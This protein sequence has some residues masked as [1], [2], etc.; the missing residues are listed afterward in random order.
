MFHVLCS[1]GVGRTENICF[2]H[3]FC[4]SNSN[5]FVSSVLWRE[6]YHNFLYAC[7]LLKNLTPATCDKVTSDLGSGCGFCWVL[8]FPQP[9]TTG[10]S[11]LN[12][13]MAEKMTK[14]EIP[15]SNCIY[16]QSIVLLTLISFLF[17]VISVVLP[18]N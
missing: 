16:S 8:W 13:N 9:F 10:K 18:H 3:K 14:I 11:Q 1:L 12:L 5:G 6:G 4:E 2:K 15:N 17:P 7:L